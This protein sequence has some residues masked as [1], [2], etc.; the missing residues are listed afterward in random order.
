MTREAEEI[1]KKQKEIESQEATL[2][3]IADEKTK[4]DMKEQAARVKISTLRREITDL[5]RQQQQREEAEKRQ[6]Q[7][8][9]QQQVPHQQT[10]GHNS[11]AGSYMPIVPQCSSD[12]RTVVNNLIS[13]VRPAPVSNV[14]YQTSSSNYPSSQPVNFTKLTL[15]YNVVSSADLKN[16]VF[17][18][19]LPVI[20]YD[21]FSNV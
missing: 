21:L 11:G 1:L 14:S 7:T 2:R 9:P 10:S 3:E 15:R 13:A 5:A 19:T 6:H 16:G 4:L 18:K 17:S 8:Q 12:P 20:F